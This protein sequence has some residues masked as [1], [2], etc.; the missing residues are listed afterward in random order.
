MGEGF[1][2]LGVLDLELN[3]TFVIARSD[4]ILSSGDWWCLSCW[5]RGAGTQ[6]RGEISAGYGG[7]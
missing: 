1:A 4:E 7:D 5:G 3:L 2:G 6:K